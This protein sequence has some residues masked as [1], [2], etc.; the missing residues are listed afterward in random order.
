MSGQQS[1]EQRTSL[2]ELV[3]AMQAETE[4]DQ[5][6]VA[7]LVRLMAQGRLKRPA[8]TEGRVRAA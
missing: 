7:R 8:G 6:V 5:E 1:H 3:R 4:D 2:A